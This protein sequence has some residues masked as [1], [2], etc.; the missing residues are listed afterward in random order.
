MSV[1]KC[2]SRCERS[3]KVRRLAQ[4]V[5]SDPGGRTSGDDVKSWHSDLPGSGRVTLVAQMAGERGAY[6]QMPAY[7]QA[8]TGRKSIERTGAAIL[9]QAAMGYCAA[10]LVS[11]RQMRQAANVGDASKPPRTSASTAAISSTN[12]FRSTGTLI[13]NTGSRPACGGSRSDM[14]R[15]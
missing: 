14:L 4:A 8:L 2:W 10:N 6:N 3:L 15:Q 11:R 13:A 5:R 7:R 12:L 9:Q 1:W